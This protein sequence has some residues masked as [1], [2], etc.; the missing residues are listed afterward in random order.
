MPVK[1]LGKLYT[2]KSKEEDQIKMI[3]DL[4][5]KDLKKID[6]CNLP[7]RYKCWIVQ[8]M[9][10]LI[11]MW[12]LNIYNIPESKIES[13]QKNITGKL[14]KWLKIPKSLSSNCF[15]SKTSKLRLPFTSL[16]EEFKATKARNTVTLEES[17]DPCIRN[18]A[19]KVD[20]GSK[21]NTP[22]EVKEAR[23]RLQMKEI[24][25][26]ANRGREGLGM[27]KRSYY[28][29]SSKKERRDMVVE[30]VRE[31]EEE[32][33]VVNMT[34]LSK[35]GAN[36]RWEVPQRYLKQEDLIKMPEARL[37]FLIK[38]VY[39][40]LP[41]P[42]NKDK[43]FNTK[44]KC[45][46]CGQDAN[47]NH[48]LSGCKTALKQGRYK[49]RH[50]QVLREMARSIQKR[51]AENSKKNQ[52]ITTG[53]K[54]IKGGDKKIQTETSK[55][56]NYLTS[57]KDWHLSVD[58]DGKLHIPKDVTTTNLRPDITLISRATRQF[59]IVELTVPTEERVEISGELKKN[60]Y[61]K[62]AQEAKLNKWRVRIW[63]VE[64]GCRGFPATS[65]LTFLKDIGYQG[66]QKKNTI[67]NI[68]K[69]A[70]QASMSLW[71]ASFYKEWGIFRGNN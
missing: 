34:S 67:E 46:L 24:T 50:D 17:A 49:W 35:Q 60:K 53:I 2:S 21:V 58:V 59:G 33:R 18:A 10:L 38:A 69:T 1:Y 65:L 37:S 71:K 3:D 7:G 20:G 61:E 62:L 25:G 6:Q 29:T 52:A 48:I 56:A 11:V 23:T 9:L 26:I 27:R 19:I 51:L 15:Y 12:P 47:L 31:K 5:K 68:S 8:H 28:S 40:L 39:D 36:L 54:F 22:S 45:T 64:V 70:E 57:A 43:W 63:A 14:K 42:A 13:L 66:R 4:V 55:Y 44:D 16:V 41:T 30:T 32:Q